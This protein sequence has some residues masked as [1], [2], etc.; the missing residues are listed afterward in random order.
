MN[1]IYAAFGIDR[2]DKLD[3]MRKGTKLIVIYFAFKHRIETTNGA[4]NL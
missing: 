1:Q 4:V 3:A 2:F